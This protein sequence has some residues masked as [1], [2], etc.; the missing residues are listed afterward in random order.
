MTL[1]ER[2]AKLKELTDANVTQNNGN[3]LF[4]I[5]EGDGRIDIGFDPQVEQK[6][7]TIAQNLFDGLACG[8]GG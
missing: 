2:R 8:F 4:T 6:V 1:E 3:G 5:Q 7:E